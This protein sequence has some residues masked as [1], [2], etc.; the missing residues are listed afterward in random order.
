MSNTFAFTRSFGRPE[1]CSCHETPGRGVQIFFSTGLADAPGG[2]N[3]NA[4]ASD[5][6]TDPEA[7]RRPF[8]TRCGART[9]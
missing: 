6:M 4:A 8:S 7:N 5:A 3:S 9:A 2:A 1:S